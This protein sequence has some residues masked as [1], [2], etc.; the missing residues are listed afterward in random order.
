MLPL[1]SVRM[2]KHSQQTEPHASF[3]SFLNSS[4]R[5]QPERSLSS[6]NIQF[7]FPSVV[8]IFSIVVKRFTKASI[9]EITGPGSA[10]LFG[11]CLE[12]DLLAWSEINRS[13]QYIKS[14]CM[15]VVDESLAVSVPSYISGVGKEDVSFQ[16]ENESVSEFFEMMPPY[17]YSARYQIIVHLHHSSSSSMTKQAIL[18]GVA[19]VV[20]SYVSF[21]YFISF[22][23]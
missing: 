5:A 20:A 14:V 13:F 9:E 7:R 22:V 16:M 23:R 1:E 10:S 18:S 15:P 2:Q 3:F 17:S 12:F 19:K 11:D 21:Q 4:N 8:R 6:V